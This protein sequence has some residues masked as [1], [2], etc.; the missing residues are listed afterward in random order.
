MIKDHIKAYTSLTKV[1]LLWTA[2]TLVK[3]IYIS[4]RFALRAINKANDK[5][6]PKADIEDEYND[7]DPHYGDLSWPYDPEY[8]QHVKESKETTND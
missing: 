4:S 1:C 7:Y 3:P 5:H 8:S 2:S 6:V